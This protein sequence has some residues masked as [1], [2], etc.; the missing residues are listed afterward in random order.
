MW[1]QDKQLEKGDWL[2]E[3]KVELYP[4]HNI[5]TVKHGNGRIKLVKADKTDW[6]TW[7]RTY[8]RL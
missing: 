7:K 3:I 8:Q 2:K 1:K 4:E 6:A 5:P